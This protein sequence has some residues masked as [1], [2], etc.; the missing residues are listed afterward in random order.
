MSQHNAWI[1]HKG[2]CPLCGK[3]I[4]W[5][6]FAGHMAMHRRKQ[7]FNKQKTPISHKDYHGC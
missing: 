1:H 6:G 4:E 3:S 2:N 5:I 7:E